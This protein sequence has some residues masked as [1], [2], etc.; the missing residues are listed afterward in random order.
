MKSLCLV[1]FLS[2]AWQGFCDEEK[3]LEDRLRYLEKKQ[4]YEYKRGRFQPVIEAELLYWKADVD[5]VAYAT[6]S[7]VQQGV[8]GSGFVG[9]PVKTRMPHFSYGPGFRLSAGI[10]SPYDLFDV[11][12]V[13]TRFNTEGKDRA[14]GSFVATDPVMGDKVIFDEIGLIEPLV[15]IPDRASAAC[16]IQGNLLELQLARGVDITYHFFIRPYFGVRA[17]WSD[18]HWDIRFK[19]DF[20]LP[21]GIDQDAAKLKIKNDFRAIGG[22]VGLQMEWKA[23]L[24][25]GVDIQGAG[26]LVWGRTEERTRQESLFIPATAVTGMKQNFKA[27]NSFHSVK[28]LWELFGGIFWEKY[29]SKRK[30]NAKTLLVKQ[31]RPPSSLRIIVGYEFQQWPYVGQKTNTQT[32][33]QRERY[34]LGFQGF[35]GGVKFVF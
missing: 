4:G 19:R 12:L 9:T 33:R 1:L 11:T 17:V 32:T 10:Q 21:E 15:S 6:T 22:L 30:L 3:S 26:S 31:Q 13:W 18:V 28:G 24:G 23:P 5:G 34:S 25:F 7:V 20:L 16:H 35:T 29:F 27:E 14:R 2:M 8:D